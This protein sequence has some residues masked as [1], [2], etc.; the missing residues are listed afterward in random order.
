MKE[1]KKKILNVRKS[2]IAGALVLTTALAGLGI[3]NSSINKQTE[4]PTQ[5]SEPSSSQTIIDNN[6]SHKP[7]L[8]G[9]IIIDPEVTDPVIEVP[10]VIEPIIKEPVETEKP[11]STPGI[12]ENN[13]GTQTS[14]PGTVITDPTTPTP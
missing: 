5:S 14:N 2:L 10:E 9:G 12:G 4:D 6:H 7:E 8:P 1:K 13:N 11:I 3:H